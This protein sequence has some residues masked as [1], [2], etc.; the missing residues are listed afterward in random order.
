MSNDAYETGDMIVVT[1]V[2]PDRARDEL[3]VAV[4]EHTVTVS[5]PGYLRE[6]PLSADADPEHL[7][8]QLYGGF[9]ELRA[10]RCPAPAARPVPVQRL[11]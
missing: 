3:S 5:A 10:P 8:A 11:R 9:L 7:H 2:V 1:L 6:L 4:S